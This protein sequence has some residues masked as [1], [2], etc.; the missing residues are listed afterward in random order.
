MNVANEV[1]PTKQTDPTSHS[2]CSRADKP[3]YLSAE[4][5]SYLPKHPQSVSAH[6]SDSFYAIAVSFIDI[7]LN[8]IP[9]SLCL[10]EKQPRVTRLQNQRTLGGATWWGRPSLLQCKSEIS[11]QLDAVCCKRYNISAKHFSSSA[12]VGE[13]TYSEEEFSRVMF[14][15]HQNQPHVQKLSSCRM[16]GICRQYAVIGVRPIDCVTKAR[17]KPH[18]LGY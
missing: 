5:E 2:K 10:L 11:V 17:V 7:V 18:T 3:G 1:H 13:A 15:R 14:E 6:Q 9:N 16:D 12:R 8:I 4:C